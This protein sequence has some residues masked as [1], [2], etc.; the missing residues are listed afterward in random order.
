MHTQVEDYP[1]Y[2]KTWTLHAECIKLSGRSDV[3]TAKTIRHSRNGMVLISR[4][5]FK[6]GTY[7]IVRM[8]DF[9]PSSSGEGEPRIRSMGLAEVRWVEEVMGEDGLTYEMGIRYV[10]TD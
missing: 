2:P 10:H 7:L 1:T 3:F 9:P 6:P 5:A 4:K 8:L